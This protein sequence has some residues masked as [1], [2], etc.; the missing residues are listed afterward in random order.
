MALSY[1][2][3]KKC[4][5]EYTNIKYKWCKPCQKNKLKNSFANWT[6]GNEK[7]DDFIQKMQLKIDEF[8]DIVFEW[9][10]YKQFGDIKEIIS[11]SDFATVY[12]TIWKDGPLCYH[13]GYEEYVRK[14]DSKV[15]LKCLHNL[16]NITN[17][18]LNGVCEV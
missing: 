17:E 15:V 13:Y 3:C 2:S 14:S 12:S 9:I 1:W 4:G 5:E 10:P 11:K 6:S 16:Q 8:D 7:I 18:F